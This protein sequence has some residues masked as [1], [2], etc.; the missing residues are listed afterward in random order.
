MASKRREEERE[1]ERGS[2]ALATAGQWPPTAAFSA[3][4]G[5][6]S[7][8]H[9]E[10]NPPPPPLKVEALAVAV[11]VVVP[12]YSLSL[13]PSPFH[14]SKQQLPAAPAAVLITIIRSPIMRSL[15]SLPGVRCF[16]A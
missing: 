4:S 3:H 10:R 16:A 5:Q 13:S 9:F 15:I 1:R 2:G 6:R 8:V 11:A 14:L 7:H 12:V